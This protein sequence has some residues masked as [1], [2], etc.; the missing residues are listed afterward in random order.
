[1]L[2]FTGSVLYWERGAVSVYM[3]AAAV[4]L[5]TFLAAVVTASWIVGLDVIVDANRRSSIVVAQ[6][7]GASPI[8]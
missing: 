2:G 3:M 4:A 6:G 8:V 7:V 1:M 5:Y